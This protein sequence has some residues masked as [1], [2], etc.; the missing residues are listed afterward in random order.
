M[1]SKLTDLVEQVFSPAGI[2][3]TQMGMEYRFEQHRYALNVCSWLTADVDNPIAP[4]VALLEGETGIGKSLAYTLPLIMHLSLTAKRALISTY[5]VNLIHQL[6]HDLS[7]I[8]TIMQQ[9]SLPMISVSQRLGVTQ[10]ASP[11]SIDQL[12]SELSNEVISNQLTEW[13][14]KIRTSYGPH[15]Y[16]SWWHDN[17]NL[18]FDGSGDVNFSL[19]D[20]SVEDD[21]H[22]YRHDCEQSQIA[23]LV[24]TSHAVTVLVSKGMSLLK[25]ELKPFDYLIA[26][27]A[28]QLG[29]VAESL[30]EH[31][32]QPTRMIASLNQSNDEVKL[33]KKALKKATDALIDFQSFLDELGQTSFA[34]K[35]HVIVDSM[36]SETKDLLAKKAKLL[37]AT[38]N[39]LLVKVKE[40]QKAA[41]MAEKLETFCASLM[42]MATHSENAPQKCIA[43]S[44]IHRRSSL[45]ASNPFAGLSISRWINGISELQHPVRMLLTSGTLS[46]SKKLG[47]ERYNSLR[48]QLGIAQDQIGLHDRHSPNN[49]GSIKFVLA[50]ET[51]PNPFV[52][53]DRESGAT[54]DASYNDGWL[55]YV[56]DMLAYS[57]KSGRTLCLCPSY[58]EVAELA[59]RVTGAADI[60]FHLPGRSL[61]DLINQLQRGDIKAIVSPSAWEG[62]SIRNA[63]GS[64]LLE[65]IF[66][67]RL[68]TSVP[69]GAVEAIFIAAYA[70]RGYSP[71]SA[72]A[73][74][75]SKNRDI[76]LR[77]F[78]QGLIGRG[79]RAIDD[80]II[81]L[82]ADPRVGLNA[83]YKLDGVIPERF[84]N[85]YSNADTFCS[86]TGETNITNHKKKNKEVLLWF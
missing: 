9:L 72:K 2:L 20:S 15:I 86:N 71:E 64:Q 41:V 43:W 60:G 82:V 54:D 46:I 69:D 8:E 45:A 16:A 73:A 29:A 1:K 84:F 48:I 68:P 6:S 26:D 70:S 12:A 24:L 51:T 30:S 44:K 38:L 14:G 79:V 13:A 31:R 22:W 33:P 75:H 62:V 40:S 63:D 83:R 57:M 10:Y 47:I 4:P 39:P 80:S 50:D 27:E 17:I 81:A 5:T 34:N 11:T 66:A 77:R 61:V 74:L 42:Q 18:D 3:V 53:R 35:D 37:V 78:K 23:Q 58:K 36:V 55:N 65:C 67:T 25:A 85:D 21:Y 7:F 49:Y 52:G 59:D 76:A 56:V 19:S 32:M 28:D